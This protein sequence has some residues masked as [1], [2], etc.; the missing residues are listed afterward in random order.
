LSLGP[1]KAALRLGGLDFK[2]VRGEFVRAYC[3]AGG[4]LGGRAPCET[5]E[6]RLDEIAALQS[7]VDGRVFQFD[8]DNFEQPIGLPGY[9]RV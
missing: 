5:A 1:A 8:A 9:R 7:G 4:G 3:R 2:D 6:E